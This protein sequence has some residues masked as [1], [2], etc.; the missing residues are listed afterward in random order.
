VPVNALLSAVDRVTALANLP[1]RLRTLRIT[2]LTIRLLI[3]IFKFRMLVKNMGSPRIKMRTQLGDLVSIT[4]ISSSHLLIKTKST[5][6]YHGTKQ[7]L[8]FHR[9][10]P[11]S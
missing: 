9:E 8:V 3:G 1:P 4:Q 6:C 11:S 5:F 10:Q 2:G 7:T